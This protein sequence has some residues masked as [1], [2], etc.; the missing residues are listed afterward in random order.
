M[1]EITEGMLELFSRTA[2][3]DQNIATMAANELALA[4][5]IPLKQ[6]ILKG[7]ITDNIFIAEEFKNGIPIEYPLAPISQ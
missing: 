4:V 5:V 1:A 6:G 2:D 3:A 7:D